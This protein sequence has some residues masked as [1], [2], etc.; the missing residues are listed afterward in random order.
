MSDEV[1]NEL[2]QLIMQFVQTYRG[3]V[4]LELDPNPE[5]KLWFMP[6]NSYKAK[7]EAS[8]YFL[9]AASCLPCRNPKSILHVNKSEDFKNPKV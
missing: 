9:L 3:I 7:K 1:S 4:D 6:L 8:H 5:P 2:T